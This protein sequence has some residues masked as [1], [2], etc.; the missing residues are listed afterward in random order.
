M[1]P[2]DPNL[3]H[4]NWER[5]GEV[6]AAIV[7]LSFILERALSLLFEHRWFVRRWK[8]RGLKEPIAFLA[9]LGVCWYWKFDAVSMIILA[10]RMTFPGYAVTAGVIAGGSKA[11]V[12][13]FRDILNFKST[14][15][16]EKDAADVEA[17]KAR[18]PPAIGRG[19]ADAG[20]AG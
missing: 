12:M 16:R 17:G 5:T 9:A 1:P 2:A 8:E 10:D 13:L 3:F 18:V 4:L 6:V 7:I 11:S 15:L 19:E 20:A 14:A